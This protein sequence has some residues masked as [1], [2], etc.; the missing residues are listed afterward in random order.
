MTSHAILLTHGPSGPEFTLPNHWR[1][2][3]QKER[4]VTVEQLAKVMER[5]FPLNKQFI[6]TKTEV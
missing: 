4:P 5:A 1:D 6:P 2:K 3:P